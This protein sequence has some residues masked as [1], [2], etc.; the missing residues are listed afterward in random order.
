MCVCFPKP[1]DVNPSSPWKAVGFYVAEK[2][3]PGGRAQVN[4]DGHFLLS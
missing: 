3:S 2:D 1:K 4:K